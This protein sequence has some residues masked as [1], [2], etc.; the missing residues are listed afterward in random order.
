MCAT[1][2]YLRFS[3][4]VTVEERK[5]NFI[6]NVFEIGGM[7]KGILETCKKNVYHAINKFTNID[8]YLIERRVHQIYVRSDSMLTV[9]EN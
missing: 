8:L 5:H 1:V 6:F 7:S 4:V 3:P 2:I 9:R